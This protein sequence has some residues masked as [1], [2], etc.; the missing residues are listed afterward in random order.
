MEYAKGP[1]FAA[2][3]TARTK[4]NLAQLNSTYDVTQLINSL[5]GLLIIPRDYGFKYINDDLLDPILKNAIFQKVVENSYPD[6]TTLK[7][8]LTHMR[9][10]VCHSRMKFHVDKAG[11][12]A[13]AKDIK[14]IEFRD[15]KKEDGRIYRFHMEISVDLLREFIFAFSDAIVDC[16]K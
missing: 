12:E 1:Q 11:A 8:V 4:E 5:V 7:S 9:N 13:A 15:S 14:I 10:A 16:I 2:D 3:F 6:G